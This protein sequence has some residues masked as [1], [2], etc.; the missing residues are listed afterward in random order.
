LSRLRSSLARTRDAFGS[1]LEALLATPPDEAFFDGLEELLIQADVGAGLSARIVDSIRHDPGA[2]TPQ[3]V[4]AALA[5]T[6]CQELGPPRDLQLQPPPAVVL[7]LGVNGSGKTTTIAKLAHRL[8][9]GGRRVLLAAAD[10]FRAAAIEQLEAW[11]QRVGADVVR[12]RAGSDPAAVVFDAA[13]AAA[14]R[15]ADVLIVDTAGRLHT[16]VNLMEE[17]KKI[18]RVVARALPGAPVERLLV[19][20][21]GTGQNGLAQA[22]HFHRAVSLTGVVL[23]KLDGTAKGGIAVAVAQQLKVPI[24]FAGVGEGVDDLVPFDPEVFAAALLTP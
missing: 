5:A 6:I 1:R 9:A 24:V 20:D 22:R 17:L 16:K 15:R 14:A 21:A 19:L 3:G 7:M 2:G 23:A 8:Q 13:Q 18:D 11:G 12:H 4:R 10:T